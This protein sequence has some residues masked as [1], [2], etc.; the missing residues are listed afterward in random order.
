MK[1]PMSSN[2][3]ILIERAIDDCIYYGQANVDDEN[4]INIFAEWVD[5]KR[6]GYAI[7]HLTIS[8]N[9]VPKFSYDDYGTECKM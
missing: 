1:S 7:I 8:E 2:L 3:I 9:G 5:S 6:S 4:G